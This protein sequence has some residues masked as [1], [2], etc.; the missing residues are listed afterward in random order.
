M[1][2]N[3]T[4]GRNDFLGEVTVAMDDYS[5][6]N[7]SPKWHTLQERVSV[8]VKKNSKLKVESPGNIDEK[9]QDQASPCEM[10]TMISLPTM[11]NHDSTMIQQ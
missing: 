9:E 1:W 7:T 8:Q 4:F 5:F 11:V 10:Q 2:H 3:D 6:S